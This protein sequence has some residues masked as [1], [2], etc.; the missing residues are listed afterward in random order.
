MSVYEGNL[1]KMATKKAEIRP[2]GT[3]E[4]DGLLDQKKSAK[5]GRFLLCFTEKTRFL[6]MDTK[7]DGFL[8]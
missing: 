3:E 6:K 2:S 7:I 5:I 1:A 8:L 4:P